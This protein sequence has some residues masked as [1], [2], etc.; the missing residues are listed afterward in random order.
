MHDR[1]SKRA[2]RPDRRRRRAHRA[3][4]GRRRRRRRLPRAGGRAGAAGRLVVG[5]LRRPGHRGR[6]R[7]A[8]SFLDAIGAWAR[9]AAAAEPILDI[10]VREGLLADPGAL[11]P[12]RRRLRA[13]GP[14][15]REPGHPHRAARARRGALPSVTLA[16][17]AEVEG[18]ELRPARV[19]GPARRRPA[20]RAPLAGLV[21]GAPVQHPRAGSESARASGPTGRPGSSAPFATTRPHRGL[22]V[23]RFFPDGP[24]ARLPMTGNRCSIVWALDDRLSQHRAGA[25]RHGLPRRDRRALRRRSGRARAGGPA[26]VTTRWRWCWRTDTPPTALALVGDAARGIHPIA[27]QGW[28][29]ALRDVAALAEIVGRPPAAGARSRRRAWRWSGTRPGGASTAWRWSRSPTA[30]TGCSPT[31][32]LPVRLAREAGLAAGRAGAAA[33]ALL[34]AARDGSGRRPAAR[35]ARR[36]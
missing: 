12:S 5:P 2:S 22:A 29:L 1:A 3:C 20:A 36:R 6:A 7:R 11:R 15:R 8:G 25:G 18:L 32:L 34:H 16:A 21:R 28:N 13:A 10:V 27:G 23:E 31:T 19:R 24:F 14:H 33:Q 30:S 17:P 35:D 26:L 4:P 9:M